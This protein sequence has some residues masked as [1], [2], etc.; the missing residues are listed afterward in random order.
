MLA[1]N[2]IKEGKIIIYEDEPFE[3]LTS[4]VFRKQQR[5]PVNQTKLRNAITGRIAEV[6]FHD[7]DKVREADIGRREAKYLYSAKGEAW[8]ADPK[9][10][11]GR[12]S[13]KTDLVGEKIK[14]MKENMMIDL[15]IFTQNDEEQI[16]GIKLPIK[17]EFEVT[18]APPGIKGDTAQGG[19]KTAKIETGAMINVPLF[20]NTGDKIRVNTE[21]GEYVERV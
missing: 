2:E 12:F 6:T 11:R 9:N 21:T 20:V 1:Y 13:L 15:M 5:K 8:F 19:T 4:W 7:S 16:T 18:E 17:M 10:L 14:F 3:V